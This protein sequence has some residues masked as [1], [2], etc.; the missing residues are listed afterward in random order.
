MDDMQE[1]LDFMV[2]VFTAG[3]EDLESLG[4]KFEEFSEKISR[5]S[6]EINA[7]M[8]PAE[9]AL[10][11]TGEAADESSK[12]FMR[13]TG[14]GLAL[15]FAGRFLSQTFGGMARSMR[16]LVGISDMVEGALTAVLS[17]AFMALVEPVSRLTEWFME[18]D[19]DTQ[20]LIGQFVI[21]VSILAPIIMIVGQIIAGLSAF[22]GAALFLAKVMSPLSMAILAVV[23]AFAAGVAIVRIFGPAIGA[24]VAI[25][26]LLVAVFIGAPVAIAA[27]VALIA[28]MIWGMRDE[29]AEA[30][31]TG[32][33]IIKSLPETLSDIA[34]D[35][36]DRASEIG[37]N[38]VNGITGFLEDNKDT[39]KNMI[40][41]FL[42]PGITID[43]LQSAGS[44]ASGAVDTVRGVN[45]FVMTDDKLLKTHPNDVLFGM[46]N[47]GELGQG[48]G[49]D[50]DTIINVDRPQLN[51]DMDV[52]RM[53]E[54]V[55]KE[56]D[57]DTRGRST[58]R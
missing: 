1:K 11:A 24:I 49:G 12:S 38:I 40:N 6:R 3:T 28:G 36:R 39:I 25:I 37:E 16:D 54:R 47:P 33:D 27:A 57:R 32:I 13:L 44:A 42:P 45:D 4:N 56:I 9:E 46:K 20:M 19:E 34:S 43:G 58:I 22:H 35:V 21:L 10:N 31:R 18:L 50:G 23:A 5:S 55:K 29:I 14:Q 2:R 51:R 53:V 15:L 7:Q 17:P 41:A 26:A 52:D 30:I 48:G 8:D